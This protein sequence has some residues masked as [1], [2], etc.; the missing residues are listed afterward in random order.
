MSLANDLI[1]PVVRAADL[2][3][4]DQEHHWLVDSLLPRRGVAMIGGAPKCAKSWTG[5]DLALSVASASPCLGHF[6]VTERAPALIYLAE[7][8]PG[9]VKARLSGIAAYRGL[10]L[11]ALPINVITVPTLRLD[12]E[13]DRTRLVE[14]VRRH[15]PRLLLLD[16][17]VRLHRIN[18]NDAG[19]VSALLAFFRQLEREYDLAIVIVHHARKNGSNGAQVG[20]GLRG[21]GDFYAFVDSLLYLRR[22]RNQLHLTVEH[23]AT[24]APPAIELALRSSD[25]ENTHLA[26]VHAGAAADEPPKTL[27]RNLDIRVL[28]VLAQASTPLSR[29]AIRA[30]LHVRN[31][32]IG[33]SLARLTD[34]GQVIQTGD[35]W[36]RAAPPP[37]EVNGNAACCTS[38]D[39]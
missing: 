25:G 14:T 18:E 15:G 2:E 22:V 31:E 27:H 39:P 23:R 38:C 16:P 8:P 1:L 34:G 20:Q 19:E 9:V 21:S 13:R 4:A 7:D 3:E 33:E 12:L 36:A 35:L 6:A 10:E 5:L 11:S 30:A 29:T 24:P 17:F 28:G 37:I 32:T 26:I